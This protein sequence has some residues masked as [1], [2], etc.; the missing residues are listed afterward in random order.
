MFANF[1]QKLKKNKAEIKRDGKSKK[2]VSVSLYVILT[3]FVLVMLYAVFLGYTVSSRLDKGLQKYFIM[4][5][6]QK[7]QLVMKEINDDLEEVDRIAKQAAS[8]CEFLLSDRELSKTIAN[9]ICEDAVGI[10][11]GDKVIVCDASGNQISDSSYGIVRNPAIVADAL[12]GVSTLNLEKIGSNLYGTALVPLKK[13]GRIVGAV[14]VIEVLSSKE[15]AREIQLHT[16]CD[17][18]VFDG[19]KRV[20][21]T[22]PGMQNTVIDDPAPIRLTEQGKNFAD[23]TVINHVPRISIYFPVKNKAGDFL[24]TIYLGKT[25]DVTQM[26]KKG[27]FTPLIF[28]IVI[29]TLVFVILIG[30]V[31]S[32]KILIPLRR[33]QKA[34]KNLT[35]GDADLTY[36]LPVKGNDEFAELSEDTNIFLNLLTEIVLK[37]KQ[38]AAEVL[39]ESEEISL[40]SQSISAGASQQAAST[41]EMS[42]TLEEIASNI[43]LTADNARATE[44]LANQS[45]FESSET[46]EVVT[47]AVSAVR[48]ISEKIQE[49]QGI[50]HQTNMLAL[51]AAIEAARAGEAGKG[52]AVVASEVR[53][54]AE[55][56]QETSNHIV[57]QAEQSLKKS[58]AAGEKIQGVLPKIEQTSSLIDDITVACK[59]QNTGAEQITSAVMHLDSITQQNASASEELAAMAEELSANAGKLVSVIQIF[60]TE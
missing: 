23:I 31:L 51:N 45:A 50:A 40:S 48:E 47:Q 60:K 26:L 42:S 30:F 16:D 4:E 14:A 18:T 44:E 53:K 36:R 21:T 27:I 10:L 38:A 57:E 17:V 43:R 25:L 15:F 1:I 41:E 56:T 35:S 32:K 9:K 29:F 3:I 54:L 28:A 13:D 49:I 34:I 33:V 59:E 19:E 8:T 5:T 7:S 12:N 2:K 37:I 20:V 6:E 55:R 52:F 46:V 24:T 58:E 11:G 22:L 39:Q